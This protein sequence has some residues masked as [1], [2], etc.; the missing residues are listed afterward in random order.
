M[1]GGP[2]AA[3]WDWSTARLRQAFKTLLQQSVLPLK[4]CFFIDGL[5]EYDDDHIEIA[6]LL[7]E[8]AMLHHVKICVASRPWIEFE[9]SFAE[10]LS[11]KLQDLTF[12]DIE[13]YVYG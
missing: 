8:V 12:A 10:C 11:L 3:S 13:L 4:W 7:K 1:Q 5:D 6:N 2:L 9:T